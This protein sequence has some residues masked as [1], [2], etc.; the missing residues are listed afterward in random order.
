MKLLLLALAPLGA[1]AWV[2]SIALGNPL[3]RS[4]AKFTDET[5]PSEAVSKAVEG[6]YMLK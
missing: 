6:A 2:T 3:R 5:V 4:V 1:S